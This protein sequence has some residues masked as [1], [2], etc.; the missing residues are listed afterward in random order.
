MWAGVE[1]GVTLYCYPGLLCGAYST[2]FKDWYR[3]V[4]DEVTFSDEATPTVSVH[5]IDYGN[6]ETL[7]S[8]K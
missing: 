5:Y 8:A 4:L 6:T 2:Y 3:V 7:S 1:G